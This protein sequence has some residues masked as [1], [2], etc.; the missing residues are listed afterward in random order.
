MFQVT[1]EGIDQVKETRIGML[2]HSYKLFKMKSDEFISEMFTRF[3]DIINNMKSLGKTYP[4]HEIVRNILECLPK[5]WKSKVTTIQELKNLKTLA[6]DDLMGSLITYEM[7][8]KEEEE[9]E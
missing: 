2:V 9:K 3:T 7:E 5:E 1:H 4:H 6:L 8:L